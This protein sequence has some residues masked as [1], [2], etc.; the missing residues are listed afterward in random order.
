MTRFD[1]YELIQEWARERNFRGGAT[2][3]GQARKLAEEFGEFIL[4]ANKNKDTKDDIGDVLVVVTVIRY[5]MGLRAPNKNIVLETP[6]TDGNH[7]FC[8]AHR[9]ISSIL[10]QGLVMLEHSPNLDILEMELDGL[11]E[12]M[13]KIALSFGFS[14][15]ECLAVAWNDIKDRRGKM[16]DG[17][18]IKE[19]DLR[20][21]NIV[22]TLKDDCSS[23]CAAGEPCMVNDSGSCFSTSSD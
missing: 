20:E 14:P 10:R 4:H 2:V 16:I 13:V 21:A 17:R 5:M 6:F 22:D 8:N 1:Y 12:T 11:E 9:G 19:S 3:F 18:F 15:E 7:L 23:L